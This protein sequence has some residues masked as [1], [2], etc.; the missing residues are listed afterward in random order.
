MSVKYL[1]LSIGRYVFTS[2]YNLNYR[3][4][5]VS[6]GQENDSTILFVLIILLE[7][8]NDNKL[9]VCVNYLSRKQIFL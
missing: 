4:H 6:K 2:V 8:V 5:S 7:N 3:F 9:R 1:K